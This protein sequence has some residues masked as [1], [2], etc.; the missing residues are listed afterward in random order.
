MTLFY[1]YKG[2]TMAEVLITIGIIGVVAAMTLPALINRTQHKELQT[3]FLKTY[4]EL[5]QASQL[6]RVKES[7]SLAEYAAINFHGREADELLKKF[8][9]YFKGTSN[10]NKGY[11]NNI[12]DD[13]ITR[14]Y[15]IKTLNGNYENEGICN[16]SGRYADIAG[17]VYSMNDAP[18]NT[19]TNGP[20]ICVDVNGQKGPNKIGYDYFLFLFTVDGYVI[21]MGQEHKNNSDKD[22]SSSEHGALNGNGFVSGEE[23]C[24]YSKTSLTS[25]A[26]CA[27]YALQ[28]RSPN[29]KG[30]YW[31]Y[32]LH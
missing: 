24:T 23:H 21:P 22:G 14:P 7:M 13:T 17:R 15:K 32:F 16:N 27:Y 30:D 1:K 2:F 19:Y 29:G 20:V 6:F 18:Q 3:A 5:N 10:F 31:N 9:G 4:S 28:N 26:S 8:M 25:G 11:W 12:D